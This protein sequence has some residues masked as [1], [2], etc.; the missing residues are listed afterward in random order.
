MD[1]W[2]DFIFLCGSSAAGLT[3]L[4]FIAVTFG[5]R[6]LNKDKL[7]RIDIFLSAICFHFVHAFILCCVASI[8]AL[9]PQV[10]GAVIVL[11][12]AWRLAKMPRAFRLIKISAEEDK[13]VEFSDWIITGVAPSCIYLL[14][15]AA[16]AAFIFSAPWAM[17]LFATSLILLLFLGM[18]GAWDMILWTAIKLN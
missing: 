6:L 13:E 15:I 5:S 8:P 1:K 7:D 2:S 3:G 9:S 12:T 10:L 14:L 16:G 18:R 11:T 17:Y 4:M